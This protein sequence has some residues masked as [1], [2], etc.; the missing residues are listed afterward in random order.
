MSLR[1]TVDALMGEIKRT[2][3]KVDGARF[4]GAANL[5]DSLTFHRPPRPSRPPPPRPIPFLFFHQPQDT[6]PPTGKYGCLGTSQDVAIRIDGSEGLVFV[7][8]YGTI[9]PTVADPLDLSNY[10]RTIRG[11]KFVSV[12]N[13]AE[14][15][16]ETY[17]LDSPGAFQGNFI[18]FIAKTIG[19][20]SIDQTIA[21]DLDGVSTRGTPKHVFTFQILNGDCG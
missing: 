6:P 12:A 11:R 15:G 19:T 2:A 8:P 4:P 7:T 5:R 9:D 10:F 3:A 17:A 18:A 13:L 14:H 16:Q 1:A 20:D 21:I